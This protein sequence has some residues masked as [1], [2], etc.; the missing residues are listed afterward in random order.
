MTKTGN[1]KRRAGQ[2]IIFF[3]MVL[4]ILV[5]VVLSN[6]DLHRILFV[7]AIS[8]NGGDSAAVA[9]ARWQ[10]ITLNL[11]GDLNVM[12]AVALGVGDIPT[13]GEI[14][15]IQARLCFVGPMI[16][17]MASQQAAKNNKLYRNADFDTLIRD[18]AGTVRNEYTRIGPDGQ[19]LF[20]EPYLG[21]WFEYS[22][23]LNLIANDG[24][25]AGPDNACLYTDYTGGHVLLEMGFYNAIST[26]DWCW[27]YNNES[28]LLRDYENFFPCWWPALP[29]IPKMEYVNSEYFGL[30]MAKVTTRLF[31]VADK[32]AITKLAAD[33]LNTVLMSSPWL[34]WATTWYCYSPAK[35][36][37]WLAMSPTNA[38]PFPATG[39]VKPQYDYAG[40][41][42]VVRIESKADLLTPAPGGGKS[43]K[44][45]VWTAAAK[46]FG[47]LNGNDLPN[48]QPLV[49][50]AFHEARLIPI[51]ASS[52]PSGG[53]FNI[54]WRKHIE[55]H[56]PKYMSDGPSGLDSSCWFCQQLVTWENPSFRRSGVEWLADNS[57]QCNASTGGG[58]GGSG[59]TS[60]GH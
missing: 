39:T 18:H 7:K 19:M 43:Q 10:G 14:P 13:A 9:A 45:V 30:G 8:Q 58:L 55:G 21:C 12:H 38:N 56:L 15:A 34:N 32:G 4:V 25:A 33:R 37:P 23:M 48:S 3:I 31:L 53:S 57:W 28:T 27:F 20:P 36:T 44:T 11:I 17:L 22:D 40:A 29:E 2:A 1:E 47:Y 35:W 6:Y 24:V 46:P 59:G 51:D 54:Q 49:L 26:G 60:T 5:F 41:D 52:A 50:P 16:S 42:A